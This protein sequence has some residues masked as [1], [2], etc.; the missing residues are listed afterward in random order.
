MTFSM[1]GYQFLE[2]WFHVDKILARECIRALSFVVSEVT[3]PFLARWPR[4][5][6][7]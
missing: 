3:A 1:V 5:Y 2:D 4:D 6:F 7:H